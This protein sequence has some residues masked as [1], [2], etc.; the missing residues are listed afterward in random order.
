MPGSVQLGIRGTRARFPVMTSTR[1]RFPS[2]RSYKTARPSHT[3]LGLR[4]PQAAQDSDHV[5]ANLRFIPSGSLIHWNGPQNSG[6][7]ALTIGFIM[8]DTDRTHHRGEER[9]ETWEGPK[10]KTPVSAALCPPPCRPQAPGASPSWPGP[11]RLAL[12]LARGFIAW[13]DRAISR[14]HSWSS[15]RGLPSPR[16]SS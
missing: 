6:R 16:L 10:R 11:L 9:S 13:H 14:G 7:P 2:A 5:A 12:A 8:K 15:W 3:C 4:G 1:S